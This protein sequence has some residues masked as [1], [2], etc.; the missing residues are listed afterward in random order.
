[1]E[2]DVTRERADYMYNFIKEVIERFGP[3]NPCSS[4]ERKAAHF[5]R[6]ELGKRCDEVAVEEFKCVPRGLF[7]WIPVAITCVL[8]SFLVFIVT[9]IV[10]P[11]RPVQIAVTAVAACLVVLAFI[12][13]WFQFFN[14]R[15]FLD[16][17]FK[18][19]G[20]QNV[21]GTFKASAGRK[22][23]IIFSAHLDSAFEFTLSRISENF[24][25]VVVFLGFGIL[26]AWLCLSIA[27]LVLT[28]FTFV[29]PGVFTAALVLFSVGIPVMGFLS[30]FIM[31]G[32]RANVVPGA[33]DDLSGISVVMGLSECLHARR[34]L[35]PPNVEVRLIAFGCEEAGLRGA[36]RY[37]ARHG[38]ELKDLN[39]EVVNMDGLELG[40]RYHVIEYE[41]TTRTLHS[42]EVVERIMDAAATAGVNAHRF[43]AGKLERTLGFA[44]GGS[45]AAAFSKAGIKAAS[46][47]SR[48]V[49]RSTH[50]YHLRYDTIDNVDPSAMTGALKIC[51]AYLQ[52]EARANA[53]AP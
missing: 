4:A 34:D 6:E 17:L 45:D 7:L 24:Q 36:Y 15:E 20:S 3:R 47:I 30:F 9:Y 41:P 38:D 33:I 31:P 21:I 51:L 23:V 32:D 2:I 37:A 13:T 1:M 27:A 35:V 52:E 5:V 29:P 39:A 26:V 10:Q 43:G 48:D 40:T 12:V 44:S 50:F 46:I 11:P 22:K 16:R 19:K 28:I 25:R 8:S 53:E 49:V 42:K 14:Y 18:E